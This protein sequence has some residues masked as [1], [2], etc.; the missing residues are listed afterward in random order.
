[1]QKRNTV[2][3]LY[4]EVLAASQKIL[5]DVGI[6]PV[7]GRENLVY[8]P[9]WSH[10]NR[11]AIDVHNAFMMARENA[12]IRKPNLKSRRP[13]PKTSRLRID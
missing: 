12:I 8:A 1:M 4:D 9:D 7:F 5:N 6:N 3:C 2:V 10:T 13:Q 11:Y